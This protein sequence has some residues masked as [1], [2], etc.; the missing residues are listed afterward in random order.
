M[1]AHH[2]DRALALELHLPPDLL[3]VLREGGAPVDRLHPLV[4]LVLLRV[5]REDARLDGLQLLI[6][7][8]AAVLLLHLLAEVRLV[9]ESQLLQTHLL[10][11]LG[12]EEVLVHLVL[13]RRRAVDVVVAVGLVEAVLRLQQR[14]HE[15]VLLV[16]ASLRL[17]S[18][19]LLHLVH[20]LHVGLDVLSLL[21]LALRFLLVLPFLVP[22]VILEDLAHRLLRLLL[23]DLEPALLLLHIDH[24][25]LHEG[26][27]LL[28]PLIDLLVLQLLLERE[29]RVAVCLLLHD[30]IM[31]L[32]GA[33]LLRLLPA[34]QVH[35]GVDVV[36]IVLLL[37]GD[38]PFLLLVD[39]AVQ[40]HAQLLLEGVHAEPLPQR[41][42]LVEVGGILV[43]LLPAVLLRRLRPAGSVALEDVHAR[44]RRDA[45]GRP[46]VRRDHGCGVRWPRHSLLLQPALEAGEV[47]LS[48]GGVMGEVLHLPPNARGREGDLVSLPLP[49]AVAEAALELVLQRTLQVLSLL[50]VHEL[51]AAR[52]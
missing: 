6:L 22:R 30:L 20:G 31:L 46:A 3:A 4:L 10:H 26:G 5:A 21:L 39:L 9:L 49:G 45:A 25:L 2:G 51:L 1:L 35:Q 23:L 33:L 42:L 34:L 47:G 28:L 40:V 14:L 18:A 48:H 36:V 19:L 27:L 32:C 38:R 8:A 16:D 52:I 12:L 50:E 37:A 41:V 43:Q 7:P 11:L 24:D 29:L 13:L 17:G 44:Q 15:T